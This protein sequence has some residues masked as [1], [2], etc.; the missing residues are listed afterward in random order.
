MKFMETYHMTGLKAEKSIVAHESPRADRSIYQLWRANEHQRGQEQ[1]YSPCGAKCYIIIY[2]QSY[3]QD[4]ENGICK[5]QK[6]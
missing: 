5:K 6:V 2:G 1:G 3:I 4:K